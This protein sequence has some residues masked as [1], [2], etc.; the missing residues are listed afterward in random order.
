MNVCIRTAVAADRQK[1]SLSKVS[2][3]PCLVFV[4][5]ITLVFGKTILPRALITSSLS[6]EQGIA[7]RVHACN[8]ST[9]KFNIPGT[10]VVTGLYP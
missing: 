3:T 6:Q 8:S 10:A 2:S 5:S 1:G 4:F 9:I 7:V